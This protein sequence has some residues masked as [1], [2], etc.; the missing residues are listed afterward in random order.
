MG[1][2]A[3]STCFA[4]DEVAKPGTAIRGE[5]EPVTSVPSPSDTS[6]R[7]LP[8]GELPGIVE[9]ED[10]SHVPQL[11]PKERNKRKTSKGLGKTRSQYHTSP[12]MC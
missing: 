5:P 10:D 4:G 8:K 6:I 2:A 7:N 1:V 11:L 3:A 12:R 9:E